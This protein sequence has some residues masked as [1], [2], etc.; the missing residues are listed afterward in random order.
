MVYL[1]VI[2]KWVRCLLTALNYLH[3]EAPH[4]PLIHGHLQFALL[5]VVLSLGVTMCCSF[6]EMDS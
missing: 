1:Q 2:R 5:I 3:Y 4:S 6:E